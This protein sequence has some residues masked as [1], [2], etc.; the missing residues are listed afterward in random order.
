MRPNF[1]EDH[2]MTTT[3]AGQQL[4]RDLDA[5]LAHAAREAATPLEFSE[6]EARLID[7]AAAA[8]DRVA[9]LRAL[10]AAELAGNTRATVAVKLSAGHRQVI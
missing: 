4:R 9:E 7:S 5:A 2:T 3:S 6:I 10:W 8:A 1:W